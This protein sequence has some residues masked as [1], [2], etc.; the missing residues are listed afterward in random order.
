LAIGSRYENRKIKN[1]FYILGY[2]LELIL[3]IWQFEK[4]NLK[5]SKFEPFFPWKILLIA[6]NHIFKVKI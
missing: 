4:K 5:S 2:L 1:C 3:N 6:G